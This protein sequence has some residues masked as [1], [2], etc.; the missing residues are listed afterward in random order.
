MPVRERNAEVNW[1]AHTKNE[2][3]PSRADGPDHIITFL[4]AGKTTPTTLSK[5]NIGRSEDENYPCCSKEADRRL[6][7]SRNE[8]NN[9]EEQPHSS[10]DRND[11]DESVQ[12]ISS[13]P[14]EQP[15]TAKRDE[16]SRINK[17]KER[18]ALEK[19]K[20]KARRKRKQLQNKRNK[21]NKIREN[22]T[23][24]QKESD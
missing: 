2:R 23:T 4:P 11:T 14:P 6:L 1:R 10:E 16:T 13:F 5:R 24:I 15:V 9:E 7:T 3:D 22:K 12:E 21:Q 18:A 8:M 20:E 19:L 17:K